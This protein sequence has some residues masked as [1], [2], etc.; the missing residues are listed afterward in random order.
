MLTRP[1][2]RHSRIRPVYRSP[3]QPP[4]P[5]RDRPASSR[6]PPC[7]PGATLA[8]GCHAA[9]GRNAYRAAAFRI[10]LARSAHRRGL[11]LDL[12]A[13]G[14]PLLS[15]PAADGRLVRSRRH[16]AVRR[17]PV[18]RPLCLRPGLATDRT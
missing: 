12:V 8:V 5:P 15:R 18:R 13:A 4:G 3:N 1:H 2:P 7:P 16:A 9:G 17:Y 14:G 6:P 11:L 10:L